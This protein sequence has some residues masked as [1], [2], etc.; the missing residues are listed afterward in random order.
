MKVDLIILIIILAGLLMGYR[1]GFVLQVVHL[2]GFFIAYFVAYRFFREFAPYLETV[3]PLP[4]SDQ[5]VGQNSVWQWLNLEPMFYS[6]LAFAILF[7]G[8]KI[9]IKLVGRLIN[10]VAML[11]IL[12]F[13]NRWLGAV[14]GIVEVLLILLVV[15]HIVLFLPWETAHHW[16]KESTFVYVMV[17]TTPFA[18]YL[19][20]VWEPGKPL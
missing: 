18:E 17:Q 8:T 2:L 16:L 10:I 12:N 5:Q 1:R 20:N 19:H 11:P 6:A 7:F 15:L 13:A 9:A 3:V 4:Y 14:L